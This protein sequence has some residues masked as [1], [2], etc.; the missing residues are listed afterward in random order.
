MNKTHPLAII[1]HPDFFIHDN[2]HHPENK[3]RL[4][5]IITALKKEKLLERLDQLATEPADPAEVAQVHTKEYI[6]SV[7]ELCE[8]GARYLDP[9]TYLV[10][11][12]YDVA[13]LSVGA[14]LLAMR[15]V[16]A[17]KYRACFSLGRPPGHHAEPNRGMGFCLFNNGAIAARLA[18]SEFNVE[19][20]LYIDWDV[21]HGNS[22]QKVFYHDP[23]VMFVSVHQSPAFPGTG[24]IEE[25]GEGKG[26]GYNV[27]IPLPPGCGDEEYKAVFEEIIV[28]LAEAYRPEVVFISAGQDIYHNDPLADMQVTYRGF[29][30]MTRTM[31]EIAD[32]F[33]GGKTVLFLEGG[34]HLQGLGE[35]V[36]TIL[37]E[38][39]GWERPVS[40]EAASA[41]YRAD[42]QKVRELLSV[43]R[44]LNPLLK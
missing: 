4:E 2:A 24:R 29:A 39:G 10:R 28:P 30:Q 6:K 26:R 7:R 19:K 42:H 16:L 11:Q 8:R 37:S 27:N 32:T 25:T 5:A 9:D 13:L 44:S 31:R 15:R 14:A 40:D 43:V 22:T 17:G 36:T 18:M 23:R 38:L 20:I 21:H 35:S 12:S 3:R 33:C 41:H 1:Y 34:Y